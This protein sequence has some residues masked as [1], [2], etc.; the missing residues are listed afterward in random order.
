MKVF[1]KGEANLEVDVLTGEAVLG[2]VKRRPIMG[3]L[4]RL[5]YNPE[6]AWTVFSDIFAGALVLIIISGLIMLKGRHGLWGIGGIELLVGILLP[7][8]FL[9]L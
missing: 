5:H 8:L 3:A 9:F 4:S 7:L 1:L 6:K 2:S